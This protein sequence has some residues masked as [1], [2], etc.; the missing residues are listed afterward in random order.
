MTTPNP[1]P[2]YLYRIAWA[3]VQPSKT[4]EREPVIAGG[5]HSAREARRFFEIALSGAFAR[6]KGCRGNAVVR[7]VR[8]IGP[9]TPAMRE[10][11][12]A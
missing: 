8:R 3:D 5:M 6:S 2:I 1:R 11:V 9:D 4:V 7:S 10:A 12:S